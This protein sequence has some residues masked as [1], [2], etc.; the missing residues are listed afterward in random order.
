V[1]LVLVNTFLKVVETGSLVSAS[2]HLNVTQ[3]TVTTR[4][5]TLE[6]EI[7]QPL[8][9]RHRSGVRPTTAGLKFQRYA[10]AM[11]GL[12]RQALL[13]TSQPSGITTVCNLGC[14]ADLWDGL[15]RPF[16]AR[17]RREHAGVALN[18]R[19]A[20]AARIDDW[21]QLGTI[22]A[23]FARHRFT[24]ER[25]RV[26]ALGAERLLLVSTDP[27]AAAVHDPGYLYVDAGPAFGREHAAAYA[28]ADV[29]RNSVDVAP[30]GL[31]HLLDHGGSAYL[32]EALVGVHL[33]A[34]RLHRIAD[35]PM[36]ERERY[37]LVRA[38]AVA[39]WPWLEPVVSSLI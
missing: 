24:H 21:L 6:Q 30:W 26:C 12:W 34:G 36:F 20:D 25:V 27:T 32:P 9:H 8:L 5:K 14:E 13:E 38:D 37:L 22:D 2:R 28:G 19:V 15:G 17:V 39:S 29:A 4:L 1:S 7:G 10:E 16:A 11:S 31:D 23:A 3:S 33:E 18:V 35:A